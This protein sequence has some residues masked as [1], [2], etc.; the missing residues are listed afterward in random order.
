MEAVDKDIARSSVVG[1]K[2]AKN[3]LLR[4]KMKNEADRRDRRRRSGWYEQEGGLRIIGVRR[5]YLNENL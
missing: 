5:R 1:C 2:N 4:N 3:R